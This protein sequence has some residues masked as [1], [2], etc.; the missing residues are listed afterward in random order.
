MKKGTLYLRIPK[1]LGILPKSHIYQ[2]RELGYIEVSTG[3]LNLTCIVVL[4]MSSSET[5]M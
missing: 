3:I 2:T 5:L 1:S 4:S